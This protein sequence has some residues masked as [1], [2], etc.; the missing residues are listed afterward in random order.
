MHWTS[1]TWQRIDGNSFVPEF[2]SNKYQNISAWDYE[3]RFIDLCMK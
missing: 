3:S 2:F 1:R